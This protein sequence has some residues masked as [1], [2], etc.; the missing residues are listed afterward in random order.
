[1][2]LRNAANT[3]R[4]YVQDT[5]TGKGALGLAAPGDFTSI[6]L[7]QD[8]TVGSDIKGAIALVEEGGGWYNFAITKAQA[9]KKC[10][11]PVIITTSADLQGYGVTLYTTPVRAKRII[12]SA[13]TQIKYYDSANNLILTAN[14]SAAAPWTWEITEA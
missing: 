14:R 7:S 9:K 8:G 10:I 11:A 13:G 3:L 4:F 5:T 2:P 6:K 12:N 1:M